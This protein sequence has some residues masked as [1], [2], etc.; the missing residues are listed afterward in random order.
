MNTKPA[1]RVPDH[2]HAIRFAYLIYGRHCAGSR[3]RPV[4]QQA[5]DRLLG[6]QQAG[7][8]HLHPVEAV[9]HQ[10]ALR[11]G[12]DAQRTHWSLGRCYHAGQKR[13]PPSAPVCEKV[14]R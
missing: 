13:L 5:V 7:R 6:V 4:L 9:E 8:R 3:L 12:Q 14:I 2:M 10:L 1:S 11:H